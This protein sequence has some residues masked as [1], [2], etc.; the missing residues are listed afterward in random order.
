VNH[1]WFGAHNR[2]VFPS[3]RPVRRLAPCPRARV[4]G[5]IPQLGGA[6]SSAHADSFVA[7]TLVAAASSTRLRI[8]PAWLARA[9]GP[10]KWRRDDKLQLQIRRLTPL[11]RGRA[12]ADLYG[13][14]AGAEGVN[15]RH[16]DDQ[17]RANAFSGDNPRGAIT[18]NGNADSSLNKNGTG[19]GTTL[20]SDWARLS[21]RRRSN[22]GLNFA[23][24]V[25]MNRRSSTSRTINW[26]GVGIF[27]GNLYVSKCSGGN[28]DD[29]IFQ[30]ENGAAAGVPVGGTTNTI[31]QLIGNQATNLPTGQA[32]WQRPVGRE[33][34]RK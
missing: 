30:V 24:A 21:R 16:S 32:R 29:G 23:S 8:A 33:A 9:D 27:N 19:P 14:T 31:V 22:W 1:A 4:L 5:S 15:Q 13:G 10:D 7:S 34:A 6:A 25:P 12:F 11:V 3:A 28:G 17:Y 20:A 18:I 26:R 2:Q